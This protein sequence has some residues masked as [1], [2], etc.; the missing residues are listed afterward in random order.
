MDG[1]P[2]SVFAL[3]EPIIFRLLHFFQNSRHPDR[4]SEKEVIGLKYYGNGFVARLI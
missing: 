3:E 4:R 1:P 2:V